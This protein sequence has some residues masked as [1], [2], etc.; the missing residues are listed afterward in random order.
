M[1]KVGFR[2]EMDLVVLPAAVTAGRPLADAVNRQDRRRLEWRGIKGARR[3]RLVVLGEHDGG[4]AAA[5]LRNKVA[6]PELVVHPERH[7]T[8][9]RT[10]A[11]WRVRQ[12]T[13]Q[14]AFEFQDRLVVERDVIQVIRGD[15]SLAKAE[16]R[17]RFRKAM[18]V[19]LA[20]EPF[21]LRGG[22]DLAVADQ[23][24]GGVVIE[25]GQTQDV[26]GAICGSRSDPS[27]ANRVRCRRTRGSRRVENRRLAR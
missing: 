22:D 27:P 1:R 18:V 15:A 4:G 21:F 6:G 10:Q 8:Q 7:R 26:H 2:L 9:K 14:Q 17:G 16:R 20:R 11:L 3:V 13:L 5:A 23:A 19:L 12:I 24:G 25:R